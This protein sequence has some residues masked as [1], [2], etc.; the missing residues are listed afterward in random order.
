MMYNMIIEIRL[1]AT[2]T[3]SPHAANP[4]YYMIF[5][6][7][8]EWTV[9]ITIRLVKTLYLIITRFVE[10]PSTRLLDINKFPLM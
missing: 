1:N 4:M 8:I 10:T 7:N 5:I 2:T 9:F 6:F 3:V